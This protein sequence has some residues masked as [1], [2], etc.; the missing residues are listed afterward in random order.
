MMP[1][2]RNPDALELARGSAA[3]ML[4]ALTTMLATLKG[5]P[6]GYNKDLQDDKRVLFDAIDTLLLV[7][8]AVTGTIAECTFDPKRMRGA[9]ATPM[10]ATD[11]A[12]YL[13]RKG[14]SF[15][16][17]HAAVGGLIRH[18]EEEAAELH[19]LPLAAFKAAH[20]AFDQDAFGAISP[21][22]SVE[23]REIDGGTGP[24]AVRR[25]IDAAQHALDQR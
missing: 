6:T 2:K 13:V 15:R 12:D 22:C 24:D 9:L 16:D 18:C 5:L 17:A 7:L 19:T 8:P 14:V 10:M 25:Q 1:Q 21:R 23:K 11:L 4:G 20:P 3:R